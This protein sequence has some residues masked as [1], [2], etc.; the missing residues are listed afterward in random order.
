MSSGEIKDDET[1]KVIPVIHK[2]MNDEAEK[3]ALINNLMCPMNFGSL[4]VEPITHKNPRAAALK[5]I[6]A[7]LFIDENTNQPNLK[8]KLKDAIHY[9]N[10]TYCKEHLEMWLSTHGRG[11][12]YTGTDGITRYSR[13]ANPEKRNL[14]LS[15]DDM[16]PDVEK[17]KAVEEFTKIYSISNL[18]LNLKAVM[19]QKNKWPTVPEMS[20]RL[21]KAITPSKR[22]QEGCK[23]F[24]DRATGAVGAGGAAAAAC[25][26]CAATTGLA[27]TAPAATG[28]CTCCATACCGSFGV[29][30][31]AKRCPEESAILC[32]ECCKE[33]GVCCRDTGD[34]YWRGGNKKTRRKKTRRKK[35]RRKKTR[36]KKTRR[37]KKSKKHK[38]RKKT[39]KK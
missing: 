25:Y 37:K 15:M 35:T 14:E 39:K 10:K 23:E 24:I 21:G 33:C 2:E 13:G 26:G 12:S 18:T 7:G 9:F 19:E 8:Y 38:K 6:E 3:Y 11:E 17:I 30:T 28:L 1:M 20:R 27:T 34:R 16:I 5:A 4:I 31:G 29:A 32:A 22:C 36:R